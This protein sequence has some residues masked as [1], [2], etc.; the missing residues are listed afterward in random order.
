M[1]STDFK[2]G[3]DALDHIWTCMSRITVGQR[4]SV[5]ENYAQ[6]R[7]NMVQFYYQR[8]TLLH[9]RKKKLNLI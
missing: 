9:T 6:Y 3:K 1:D 2:F 5:H 7:L 8:Q 4:D